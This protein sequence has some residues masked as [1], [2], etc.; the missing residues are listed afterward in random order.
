MT[1]SRWFRDY[2]Y[3]P[4]GGNKTVESRVLLNVFL[5]AFVSG[6]WHGAGW[7]F[8]IWGALH[9]AAMVFHRLWQKLYINVN[10]ALSVLLTFC[11]INIS[12]V[13]FRAESLSDAHNILGRMFDIQELI[14]NLS[15]LNPV[16]MI[17]SS[18]QYLLSLPM[19]N[20]FSSFDVLFLFIILLIVAE[21]V[22][23][24]NKVDFANARIS[25]CTILTPLL[26]TLSFWFMSV[27]TVEKFI[28]FNF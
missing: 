15:D 17:F 21:L 20:D 16:A 8:L 19:V 22:K 23:S 18:A 24:S 3:I 12:W 26:L 4:L 28:Y 25:K 7:T 9:G 2:V 10:N 1:L 13:Y 5:T 27:E 6:I 14:S 11:F